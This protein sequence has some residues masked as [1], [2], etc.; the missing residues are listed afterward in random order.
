[1]LQ[2]T[3]EL[4]RPF[5]PSRNAPP[6]ITPPHTNSTLCMHAM[7]ESNQDHE[8]DKGRQMN[9]CAMNAMNAGGTVHKAHTLAC[10]CC[11]KVNTFR[12]QHLPYMLTTMR[13]CILAAAPHAPALPHALKQSTQKRCCSKQSACSPVMHQPFHTL[14]NNQ[15]KITAKRWMHTRLIASCT[16]HAKTPPLTPP[17]HHTLAVSQLRCC[18]LR[19]S[20]VS[21]GRLTG[22]VRT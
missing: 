4:A 14:S 5:A 17:L 18:G 21:A 13:C 1:M 16:T 3:A 19:S 10:V 6:L 22:V 2:G 8:S 12:N 7:A 11:V 15:H 20:C 9:A